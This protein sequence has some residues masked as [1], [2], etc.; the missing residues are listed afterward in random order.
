MSQAL[1]RLLGMQMKKMGPCTVPVHEKT[2]VGGKYAR[3]DLSDSQASG[4]CSKHGTLWPIYKMKP[5]KL[6][7]P[8]GYS[9]LF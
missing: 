8:C 3:A 1:C 2:E 7:Q 6:Q 5:W 9:A 4:P